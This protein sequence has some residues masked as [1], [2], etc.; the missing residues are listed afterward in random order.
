MENGIDVME[1]LSEGVAMRD[2]D[3][4]AVD[5]QKIRKIDGSTAS[6]SDNN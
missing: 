4:K 6:K 2:I 1:V 3:K 5:L